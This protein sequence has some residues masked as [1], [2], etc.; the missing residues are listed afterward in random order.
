MRF[1]KSKKTKL[2]I[3]AQQFNQLMSSGKILSSTAKL[4]DKS[5][6]VSHSRK[7]SKVKLLSKSSL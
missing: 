7:P 4:T 2:G 6:G 3:E 5:K 1:V